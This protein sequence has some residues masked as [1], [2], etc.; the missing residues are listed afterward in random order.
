MFNL[1]ITVLKILQ[2]IQ[3]PCDLCMQAIY[4]SAIRCLQVQMSIY[5]IRVCKGSVVSSWA[6]VAWSVLIH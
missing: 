1:I 2:T 5:L 3:N 6:A 4:C